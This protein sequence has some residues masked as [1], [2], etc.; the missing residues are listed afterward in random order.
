MSRRAT[1]RF[2]SIGIAIVPIVGFARLRRFESL[3]V[4]VL[5]GSRVL[6]NVAAPPGQP[7]HCGGGPS[8]RETWALYFQGKRRSTIC[9]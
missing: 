1:S 6:K 9:R 4:T 7:V 2:A 8:R 3:S 5:F